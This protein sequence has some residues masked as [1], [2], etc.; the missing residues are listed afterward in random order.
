MSR[1]N[2]CPE[3]RTRRQLVWLRT[4]WDIGTIVEIADIETGDRRKEITNY[5]WDPLQLA[6]R[7]VRYKA[8]KYVLLY[9]S[10]YYT[11][12][13]GILLKWLVK[14][15][16]TLA[17]AEVHEGIYEIHQSSYKI[18]SILRRADYYWPMML[19]CIKYK[20]CQDC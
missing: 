5:L 9:I 8:I 11:M 20:R 1:S 12:I 17:M 3:S 15:D 7:K 10:S 18:K 13:D 14:E 4:R 19:D 16:V 6:P 2:T